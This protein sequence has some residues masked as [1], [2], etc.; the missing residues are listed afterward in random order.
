MRKDAFKIPF[1]VKMSAVLVDVVFGGVDAVCLVLAV[2]GCSGVMMILG[3]LSLPS[4]LGSDT[5]MSWAFGYDDDTLHLI[6]GS[7]FP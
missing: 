3:Q 5:S 6:P 7:Y 4:T 1:V 2:E